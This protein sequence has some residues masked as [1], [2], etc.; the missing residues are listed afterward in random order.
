MQL[1]RCLCASGSLRGTGKLVSAFLKSGIRPHKAGPP[2]PAA[3]NT[4]LTLFLSLYCTQI[5]QSFSPFHTSLINAFNLV[6]FFFLS[7][8]GDRIDLLFAFCVFAVGTPTVSIL[9]LPVENF[10]TVSLLWL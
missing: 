6:N 7:Y 5:F 1:G 3:Q 2:L 4:T 9:Y 10:P 8:L